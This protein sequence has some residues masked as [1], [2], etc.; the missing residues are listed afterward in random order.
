MHAHER[1]LQHVVHV[2]ERHAARDV[3]TKPGLNLP[4]RTAS[5]ARNHALLLPGAQ[6][7]GPQQLS[8]ALPCLRPSIV[9]DA[10]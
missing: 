8:L 3:G 5:R 1:V 4:P 7:D 10:T 9:A 6:Q 2:W